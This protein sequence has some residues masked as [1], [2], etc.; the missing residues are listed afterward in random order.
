MQ[1]TYTLNLCQGQEK[2]S[3]YKASSL[4]LNLSSATNTQ[5]KVIS[6]VMC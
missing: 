1:V 3:E 5:M 2:G 6:I 4:T